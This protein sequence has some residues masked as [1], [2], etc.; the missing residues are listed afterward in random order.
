MLEALQ[1]VKGA[2]AKK[3]TVPELTHF[4]I[5]GG[6]VT[7]YNGIMA[8]SSPIP[9]DIEA[10]PNAQMFFRAIE[11]CDGPTSLA[12]TPA[13]RIVVKSG[14]M[15]ASV[16]CIENDGFFAEPQ[17]V[18]YPSPA[19]ITKF[20]EVVA[21][22]MG[23]DASRP[24]CMGVFFH[25]PNLFA[26]NNVCVIQMWT[27]LEMPPTH[28]P[29]FAVDQ[30]LRYKDEPT[31]LQ[32]DGSSLTVHYPDGRWLRTQLFDE[33]W[34]TDLIYKLLEKCSNQQTPVPPLLF[35]S[36]ES[37]Y[38]FLEGKASQVYFNEASLSSAS[39]PDAED[40]VQ[41]EVPDLPAGP[42]FNIHQLR[43]LGGIAT[44]IDFSTYPAPCTFYGKNVRGL[45]MGMNRG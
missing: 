19:G 1:F 17:G 22:F 30:I 40:V 41:F 37:L 13:N 23:E 8:L 16:P 33:G 5:A 15:K 26:T 29:K 6:R 36:V 20:L 32:T 43:L 42:S 24:W 11:A 44:H 2:V 28:I 27:G 39:H 3:A 35:E 10:S 7:G 21:P 4:R 14:R 18:L 34:P 12:L 9:T 25:G 45:V 31:Q 38:P